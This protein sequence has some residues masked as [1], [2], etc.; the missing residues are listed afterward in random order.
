M[1][2]LNAVNDALLRLYYPTRSTQGVVPSEGVYLVVANHPNGLLDPLMVRLLVGRPTGF[3][4][5]STF[6]N[7]PVGRATMNAAGAMPV[8]RA[9]EADTAK[10]EE[11]FK[12]CRALL[13]RGEWLALFPEGKSHSEPTL[14]PLKSGAARIALSTLAEAPELALRVLPVGVFYE[15]KAVFRSRATGTVGDPVEV[16]DLLPLYRTDARAAVE[17]LTERVEA[18]LGAVVLQGETE[19]LRRAFYAVAGWTTARAPEAQRTA[20]I[21]V[22]EQ[23]ARELAA[24]W[25]ATPEDQ[26]GA[27][28][29]AFRQ[30][31]QRMAA[32]GVEDPL[33]VLEARP[34]PVLART[35]GLLALLPIAVLGAVLAWV[36]YRLV[37]PV[38]S[39]LARGSEDVLGT[40]K[41]LL[42]ALVLTIHYLGI[43]VLAAFAGG[44]WLGLAAAIV[45][46]LSGYMAL[47]FDERWTLRREALRGLWRARDVDVRAALIREREA[48]IGVISG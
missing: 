5:K 19:E 32:L 20:D 9:H 42:G 39:L 22:R 41:V 47:R 17:A 27:A 24:R 14:Q 46:P 29:I 2:L 8:Y 23:R 40:M 7:N 16:A 1:N 4:A 30:F 12:R 44:P 28:I 15:D 26:R 36:P 37:R 45:G 34:G 3:L 25:A 38:A 18:A 6:W 48:L 31:E 21:A 43:A 11:T 10:N 33:V 35:V 13:K